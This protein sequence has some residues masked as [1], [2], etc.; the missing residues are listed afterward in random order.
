MHPFVANRVTV[1]LNFSLT[2][3]FTIRFDVIVSGYSIFH[4][5]NLFISAKIMQTEGRIK[6]TSSFFMP[7]C[8]LS[9][10]LSK[11]TDFISNLII[12]SSVEPMCLPRVIDS[13]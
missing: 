9:S 10:F 5:D 6:S 13:M 2:A 3:G 12:S 4:N 7:R 11:D 8:S 1:V